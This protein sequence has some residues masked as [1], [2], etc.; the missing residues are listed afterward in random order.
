MTRIV[1]RFGEV[2]VMA[3]DN[4][5]PGGA[6]HRYVVEAPHQYGNLYANINFQH[7]GV[8]E[9]GLNGLTHEILLAIVI[10]RLQ[11]FQQGAFACAE[12]AEALHYAD[13]A[14]RALERRTATRQARGVEGKQIP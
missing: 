4:P 8:A 7:G 2:L 9:T 12:N 6:N 14:L 1:R 10:D 5:G 11:A 3:E 13:A